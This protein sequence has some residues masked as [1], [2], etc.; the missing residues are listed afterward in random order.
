MH[1]P[2]TYLIGW[3][4][5]DLWYY[6]VRTKKNCS[7]GDL[8]VKYFTSSKRVKELRKI[9]GEPDV[10][11]IRKT[12]ETAKQALAWEI[13][14][15]RRLDVRYSKRWINLTYPNSFGVQEEV[16]NL[17]LTKENNEKSER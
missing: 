1:I 5:L 16:W 2:Y 4:S 12:F 11:Q 15:L 9:H 3:S 10:I 17:G 14:V 6:G 8:W 7:P 13:K